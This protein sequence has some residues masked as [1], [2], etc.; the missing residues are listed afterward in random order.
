MKNYSFRKFIND[1][2]LWLGIGS[3]I[4]IFIIC[5]SGTILVFQEEIEEIFAEDVVLNGQDLPLKSLTN[6]KNS[7]SEAGLGQLSSITIPSGKEG[8]YEA[9]IK[10]SPEDRRGTSFLVNPHTA[11]VLAQPESA[12][13]EFMFSMF[14]LHRWLL[15]D[16]SIG[17]PI[18]GIATIIFMILSVSGLILWFPRKWRWRNFKQGFKIK[19]K[20]NWKRIN[21]DLHNTLGFYALLLIIIMGLTGLCWSFEWYREAAG[22]VIGTKVFNRG[23]GVEFDPEPVSEENIASLDR[24]Y[25]IIHEEF[26]YEGEVS[27]GLPGEDSPVYNIRKYDESAFSPVISNKLVLDQSGKVLQKDIFSDKPLNV[28]IASLIKPIHLGEIYGTFSKI[29]YFIACLIAT[30]LPVTGTIIWINKLRKKSSKKKS[31]KKLRREKVAA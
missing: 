5:L 15:L 30:S 19:T 20:A 3:G 10:T 14:K 21:H 12:A 22:A 31:A 13:S 8:F 2:H 6:L 11:E 29:L 4:I 16:S 26:N 25:A 9:R 1:I 18:V 7:I 28:Q 24:I 17:R 23:G 27:I